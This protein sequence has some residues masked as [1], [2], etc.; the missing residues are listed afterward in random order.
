MKFGVLVV[1]LLVATDLSAQGYRLRVDS[2]FQSVSFRGIGLDS[3][4]AASAITNPGSGP[5]SPGGFAVDCSSGTGFCY[6]FR[7]A[8]RRRGQPLTA[9]ADLTV[10]GFGVTGLTFHAAARGATDLSTGQAWP[11]TEPDLLLQEAYLDYASR[12]VRGRAGRQ[13]VTGRLG[14][15]GLDGARAEWRL[16]DQ[17]LDIAGYGGFGLAQALAIPVTSPVLN[18]LDDFQPRDRQLVVGAEVGV[19][20]GRI[21]V[22]AE[23]RR[24]VD[25]TPDYLV[26]ERAAATAEVQ[27]A[28]RFRLSGGA[29]YDFANGWW[30]TAEVG[31]SYLGKRGYLSAEA[32]RYRPFFDLWTIWGAFSPVPYRSLRASGGIEPVAGLWVRGS[33]ERY[34]FDGAEAETGLA[35]AED[36]GWRAAGNASY[37]IK[38]L[39]VEAGLRSEFGPGASSRSFDGGLTFEASDAI[40]LTARGGT[41][42][43][44]LEF[45]YSDAQARWFAASGDVRLSNQ[46][47][48]V[49]DLM[50]ITEERDRPDAAAFDLDQ[51]RL[52]TRLVVTFGSSADRLPPAVRRP[53]GG[54][55]P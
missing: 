19:R 50:A 34:R 47:R 3:I 27:L 32:R 23:Y 44:P 29:E 18:P 33:A 25:P 6:F 1:T 37:R 39:T 13:V 31:A 46:V 51:V 20:R 4:P 2:R 9:N 54:S 22:R 21:D 55:T 11:G 5:A 41:L 16:P 28:S 12:T 15:Q 53:V 10:W 36:R 26:S 30:G 49:T 24:E 52:S 14:Y 48:L 7:P 40:I 38:R 35:V 43:R 8:A 17:G 45:R 42:D